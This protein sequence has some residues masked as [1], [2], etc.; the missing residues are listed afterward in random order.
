MKEFSIEWILLVIGSVIYAASTVWIQEVNIIPGSMLGIAVTVHKITRLPAG[1]MNLLLNIPIMAVVTRKMGLKTLL[2]TAIILVS[3]GLLINLWS[4]SLPML[5]INNIYALALA[6]GIA[7]GIGAG[8]LIAAKGTM[9]GTTALALLISHRVNK[10][11][12]GTILFLMDSCIVIMGS[13]FVGDWNAILC[14]EV[15]A[16]SCAKMIDVVVFAKDRLLPPMSQDT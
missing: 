13:V 11:S 5:P 14:S 7:M 9:A 8:L 6:D 12:Y 4:A 16:F 2:Y 3:S 1:T 15:Y 10:L